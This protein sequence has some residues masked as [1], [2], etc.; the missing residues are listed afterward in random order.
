MPEIEPDHEISQFAN[1]DFTAD[2]EA[3]TEPVPTGATGSRD[4]HTPKDDTHAPKSTQDTSK[5]TQDTSTPTQDT[6]TP[7]QDRHTHAP[8]TQSSQKPKSVCVD[9]P[10]AKVAKGKKQN[11]PK[12]P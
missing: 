11:P 7:T 12:N 4:N 9:E 8:Q 6:S 3:D 2:A 10:E 5:S 1:F